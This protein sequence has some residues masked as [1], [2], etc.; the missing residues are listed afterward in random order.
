MEKKIYK[1]KLELTEEQIV[2]MPQGS[3]ILSTQL[4]DGSICLWAM[5]DTE[6]P[7]KQRDIRIYGT[8]SKITDLD[9]YIGTVQD[10]RYVWHV[11]E[12]LDET[13]ALLEA[14]KGF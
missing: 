5:V 7:F 2:N 14:I 11:W 12:R 9:K 6:K 4:Q 13:R 3:K 8:G 1:Y 10:G